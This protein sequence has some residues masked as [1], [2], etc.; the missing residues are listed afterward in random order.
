MRGLGGS[1]RHSANQ[2][3]RDLLINQS[4][5]VVQVIDSGIYKLQDAQLIF[6]FF[7]SSSFGGS[8]LGVGNLNCR[9]LVLDNV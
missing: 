9:D 5:M 2:T 8:G 4:K 7:C 3:S 1:F 6:Y